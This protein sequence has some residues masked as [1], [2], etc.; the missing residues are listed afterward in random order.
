[1]E[2]G[3]EQP[4]G[5]VTL[6]F[7]D[8]EGS[9][10]LLRELGAEAYREV[11]GEH[12]RVVRAAFAEHGGYEVGEEGDAFFFAFASAPAAVAAV[13]EATARLADGPVRVRVGVHTGEPLVDPP[14]YVGEDVH[15]AARIMSA[16]HG[17]QVLLSQTTRGLVDGEL[18]ELGEHRLKDFP[19]AVALFQLGDG[20]FPPLRTISNT[21][22]PRPVSSFVGRER[23]VAEVVSLVRDRG[24]R[25]VTLSGPGGTG[26]TRLAIEAATE[27]VGDFAAGVYWVELAAVRDPTLVVG[28]IARTLGANRG[29]AEQIGER[30]LLLVLDNLEQ[31]V[32]AAPDLAALLRA[33]PRL[34]L[35]VTSRELLRVEGEVAYAVPALDGEE[36]VELFCARARIRASEAVAELC[37]RLDNLPLAVEL[38]A[39]RIGVLSPE[40]IL[41]RV[42]QRLDLFRGGRDADARQ[43]TLRATISWS[44]DLLSPTE[45]RLYARLSVFAGGFALEAA[46][47]VCEAALDTL[48]SLVDKNLLRHTGERFWM[49]ETIREFAVER[50]EESAEG[51]EIQRRH[52]WYFL[53]LFESHDDARRERLETLPEYV[54]L[55]RIEQDNVTRALAWFRARN[56][57][58]E[59]ARIV[60]VLHPLWMESP[61]EG[62]RILDSVLAYQDL[63]DEVRGRLLWIA[64]VVAINQGDRASYKRFLEEA[65]PLFERLGDRRRLGEVVVS[66]GGLA[67]RERKFERA[68][69]LLRES[70]LIAAELGDRDLLARAVNTEAHIPLYEGDLGQAERL[71]E[72]ALRLAREAEAPEVVEGALCNL[73]LAVLEQGRF[74]EAASLYRESLSV[75]VELS[76]SLWELAAEG[77]AAVA[78]ARGDAATAA[79]LLGAT[80]EWRR[81]AG[82]VS[83][84]PEAALADRT[85]AAAR[86]ALGD[87]AYS[88]SVRDG[89]ALELDEAV[90]LALTIQGKS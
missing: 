75:R 5:T 40:Q 78:V 89:A 52:A 80:E 41:E 58:E 44:F 88:L 11:L 57:P 2:S 39:A 66:L 65:L 29:V 17:G 84:E 76:R 6:V 19:E 12:R 25:L 72:E 48:E 13:R 22:L 56:D 49:L 63:S 9:T 68:H 38:A 18:R 70:K 31:V 14:N 36:A 85:A 42:S 33:C 61:S 54:A 1:M 55:V 47:E 50:L 10:V 64:K 71:F 26:K 90:E 53:E 74:D 8:I 60:G 83:D 21:N 32:E 77:L 73:A 67:I 51:E 46:G 30:E 37:R 35:L 81:K 4:T 43:Q 28:E 82:F 86:R 69:T 87:E 34:R 7:T 79:R 20:R 62:R 24:A 16:G 27:L 3:P 59:S 23:E 15:L 45:Q